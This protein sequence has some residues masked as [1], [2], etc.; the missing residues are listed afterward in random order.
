MVDSTVTIDADVQ[1]GIADDS[2]VK[3]LRTLAELTDDDVIAHDLRSLADAI[4]AMS[5]SFDTPESCAKYLRLQ[6]EEEDPPIWASSDYDNAVWVGETVDYKVTLPD[7]WVY[8]ETIHASNGCRAIPEDDYPV[9]GDEFETV[10]TASDAIDWVVN[11]IRELGYDDTL[12]A[13]SPYENGDVYLGG[14]R[15]VSVDEIGS[16]D[17][18]RWVTETLVSGNRLTRVD[19]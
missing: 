8:D 11:R 16:P 9:D 15:D 1:I 4:D 19:E 14:Q 10:E 17:G 5:E 12:A 6:V 2:I 13:S 3:T 7:G 18:W